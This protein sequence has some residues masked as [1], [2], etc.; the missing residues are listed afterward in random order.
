M[1]IKRH[2]VDD[3]YPPKK[4]KKTRIAVRALAEVEPKRYLLHEIRRNDSFGK[5]DYFELPGGKVEKGEPYLVALKREL[6]EETGYIFSEAKYLGYV[7]DSYNVLGWKNKTHYFLVMGCKKIQD[8]S[9]VSAGDKLIA[10]T[11]ILSKEEAIKRLEGTE[12]DGIA[13]LVKRREFPFWD[14]L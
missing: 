4:M 11:L 9:F 10:K 8:P 5:Y 14:A 3:Q 13:I 1:I 7:V 6:L 2:L 12:N